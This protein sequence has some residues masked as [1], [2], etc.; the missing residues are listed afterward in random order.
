[1]NLAASGCLLPV[2]GSARCKSRGPIFCVLTIEKW[3]VLDPDDMGKGQAIGCKLDRANDEIDPKEMTGKCA[4]LSLV[5]SSTRRIL[6]SAA[7]KLCYTDRTSLA[8]NPLYPP[9]IYPP[10]ARTVC[11]PHC[12]CGRWEQK[13]CPCCKVCITEPCMCYVCTIFFCGPCPFSCSVAWTCGKN[14]LVGEGCFAMSFA[15]KDELQS[16]WC[17]CCKDTYKRV[18]A[19][20]GA[21][22]MDMER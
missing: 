3:R 13:A 4:A 18:D 6:K 1:L 7:Q 16:L 14:C 20:A 10:A 17:L 21:P 2:P 22:A 11:N 12:A 15:S 9:C 19:A 5:G 8:C